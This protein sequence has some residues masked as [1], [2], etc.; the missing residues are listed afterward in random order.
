MEDPIWRES[1]HAWFVIRNAYYVGGK[2]IMQEIVLLVGIQWQKLS[3]SLKKGRKVIS[4]ETTYNVTRLTSNHL[5]G[6]I[7]NDWWH[8]CK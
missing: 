8:F 7:K 3:L 6:N 2:D 4:T 1:S 5:I